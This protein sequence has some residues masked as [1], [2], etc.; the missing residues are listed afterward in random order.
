MRRIFNA[1]NSSE[2][3]SVEKL[4]VEFNIPYSCLGDFLYGTAYI[5]AHSKLECVHLLQHPLPLA[6][7]AEQG[8][9]PLVG[10]LWLCLCASLPLCFSLSLS[11]SLSLCL[12]LS[13]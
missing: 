10:W 8:L 1:T 11:V 3:L 9:R 6:V 5:C 4:S 12:S 2:K 7:I 13:L